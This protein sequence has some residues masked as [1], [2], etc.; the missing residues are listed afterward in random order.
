MPVSADVVVCTGVPDGA[1]VELRDDICKQLDMVSMWMRQEHVVD[2]RERCFEGRE[3]CC[4]PI[5]RTTAEII[6]RAAV[7]QE[8]ELRTDQENGKART[9]VNRMQLKGRAC[10]GYGRGGICTRNNTRYLL[11]DKC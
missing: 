4:N 6:I 9:N 11:A 1:N 7:V 2:P 5:L 10:E 8:I 3:I